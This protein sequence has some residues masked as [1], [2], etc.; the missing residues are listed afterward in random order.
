MRKLGQ[1]LKDEAG[2]R[3]ALDYFVAQVAEAP[4]AERGSVKDRA[5]LAFRLLGNQGPLV[6]EYRRKLS[7]LLF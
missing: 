7:A 6:N 3:S 1:L 5:L 4:A 2:A